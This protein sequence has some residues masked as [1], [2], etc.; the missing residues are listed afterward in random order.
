MVEKDAVLIHGSI[1]A[2][3]IQVFGPRCRV[4]ERQRFERA[5]LRHILEEDSQ[6]PGAESRLRIVLSLFPLVAGARK[7]V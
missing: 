7:T 2:L 3:E 5:D 6:N 4:V 1:D